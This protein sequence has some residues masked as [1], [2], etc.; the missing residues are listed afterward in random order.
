MEMDERWWW[1]GGE[2]EETAI[3]ILNFLRY[4]CETHPCG[5][6]YCLSALL[7]PSIPGRLVG[8][9]LLGFSS[10]WSLMG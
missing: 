5:V 2:G 1:T 6:R 10:T 4:S 9:V 3:D 7:Y 8:L